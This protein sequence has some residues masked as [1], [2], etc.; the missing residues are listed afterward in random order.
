MSVCM[1]HTS[2]HVASV[3]LTALCMHQSATCLIPKGLV[4]VVIIILIPRMSGQESHDYTTRSCRSSHLS[5]PRSPEVACLSGRITRHREARRISRHLLQER[6]RDVRTRAHL[7]MRRRSCNAERC[8]MY[9]AGF[10]VIAA[11]RAAITAAPPRPGS[12]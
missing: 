1:T 5:A 12:M 8:E 2:R 4:G 9:H 6:A 7:K 10:S 3:R 11:S